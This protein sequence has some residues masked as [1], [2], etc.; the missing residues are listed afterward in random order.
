[1][2]YDKF[3]VS[4]K[5]VILSGA[6]GGI[7]LAITKSFLDAGAHIIAIV[8]RKEVDWQG[9]SELYPDNLHQHLCDLSNLDEV[10]RVAD[11]LC[12]LY[13][14]VDTLINNACPNNITSE[15]TYDISI[16]ETVRKV[17]LD[18]PYV[19]CGKI[20]PQMAAHNAGSIINIT[21]INAEAAWPDNP[22][23]VT[24]KS[25]LRMLTKSVARDFG[26]KGVRANNIS[27][28]YIHTRMTDKSFQNKE[29][30]QARS[31]KTMLNRWGVPEEVASTCIFLASDASS[32]ITG[33]DIHVDGGWLA[34]G[35]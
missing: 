31:E 17:G 8:R 34:K 19:L 13:P 5:Y 16:F 33:A 25:G 7:G 6:S 28:G 1:M 10:N 21:S 4:G 9:L 23:Y 30:Y 20:S 29:A 15:D 11:R 32:Y 18:A 12:K 2:W 24:V 27:P 22:A 35:L 26:S 14:K 3:S